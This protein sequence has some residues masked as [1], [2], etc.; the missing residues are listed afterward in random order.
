VDGNP[1]AGIHCEYGATQSCMTLGS[2][3]KHSFCTNGG[4]CVEI[5]GDNEEHVPCSCTEGYTGDKCEYLVGNVPSSYTNSSSTAAA[6][7]MAMEQ[8]QKSE[9]VQSHQSVI[10]FAIIVA[11][12]AMILLVILGMIM[13]SYTRNREAKRQERE[14]RRAT[15]DFTMVPMRENDDADEE[16]E[17]GII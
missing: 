6:S 16:E 13:R 3:S 5:V 4:E 2:E 17:D 7:A 11:M 15:E 10:F 1:Y 9:S 8:Q 14:A 12:G